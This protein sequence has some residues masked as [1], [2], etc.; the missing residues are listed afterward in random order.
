MRETCGD[1]DGKEAVTSYEMTASDKSRN[2][3]LL[4][5]R[6]KNGRTHQIRV[7]MAYIGCPLAGDF[8]YGTEYHDLISRHALHMGELTLLH[9]LSKTPL[10]FSAPLPEDMRRLFPM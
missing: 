3:A 7:H 9:P 1:E 2:L 4:N 5:I 8:L 10:H 6:T